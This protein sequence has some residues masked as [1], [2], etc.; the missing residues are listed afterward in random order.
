VYTLSPRFGRAHE[1]GLTTMGARSYVAGECASCV[2]VK[3][4]VGGKWTCGVCRS[5][6]CVEN[7][8]GLEREQQTAEASCN[9]RM[10]LGGLS[11]GYQ[12]DR[13]TTTKGKGI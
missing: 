9:F 8:N 10:G 1:L 3:F 6:G 5:A 2:E 11:I 4:G 13:S 12:A 7:G